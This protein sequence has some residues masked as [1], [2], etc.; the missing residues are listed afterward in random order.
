MRATEVQCKARCVC[1]KELLNTAD[2]LVLML[3]SSPVAQHTIGVAALA[4]DKRIASFTQNKALTPL[5]ATALIRT[6]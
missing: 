3:P 1:R 4:A 5:D 6:E 2:Y